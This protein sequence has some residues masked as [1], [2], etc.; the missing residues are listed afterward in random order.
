MERFSEGQKKEL[1]RIIISFVMFAVIQRRKVSF[2][3]VNYMDV[4]AD[5]GP[6]RRRIVVSEYVELW[7]YSCRYLRDVRHKVVRDA[8]WLFADQA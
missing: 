1:R 5:S 3:Q 7:P 8:V 2:C 6:V 4:V